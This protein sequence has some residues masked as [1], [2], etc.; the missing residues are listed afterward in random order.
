MEG[1][2]LFVGIAAVGLVIHLFGPY[3][4]LGYGKS[5]WTQSGAMRLM[6]AL[7]A[8]GCWGLLRGAPGDKTA[9]IPDGSRL[10]RAGGWLRRV[11]GIGIGCWGA[12]L[13]ILGVRHWGQS[14]DGFDRLLNLM[15][16]VGGPLFLL[17]GLAL[18]LRRGRS[19]A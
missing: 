8:A 1:L 9:P 11:A 4:E 7:C 17:M 14:A 6:L 2:G 10:V 5:V 15:F 13:F 18:A 12:W 16:V 3:P 19:D